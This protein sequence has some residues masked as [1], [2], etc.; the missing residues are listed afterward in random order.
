MIG[1]IVRKVET[2]VEAFKSI[3]EDLDKEK[4]TM[5]KIWAK[6]ESRLRESLPIL[7]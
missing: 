3:N 7:W 5:L 1:R 2:I 4:R 6:R